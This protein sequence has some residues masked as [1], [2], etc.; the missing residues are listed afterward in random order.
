MLALLVD[1]LN[2]MNPSFTVFFGMGILS[3]SPSTT[4][5]SASSLGGF[6][7]QQFADVDGPFF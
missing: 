7:R 4:A 6:A 3:N 2:V 1:G 5:I